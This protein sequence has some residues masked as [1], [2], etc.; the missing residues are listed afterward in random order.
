MVQLLVDD[1]FFSAWVYFLEHLR[2][3]GQYGKE[4]ALSLSPLYHFHP[5]RKHLDINRAISV[6]R[7]PLYIPSSRTWTENL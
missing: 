1:N 2:F 4:K 7:S 6:E 5:L 3:T